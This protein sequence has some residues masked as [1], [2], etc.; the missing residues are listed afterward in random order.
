MKP[1][2]FVIIGQSNTGKSYLMDSLIDKFNLR[3]IGYRMHSIQFENE[4]KGYYISSI[5]DVKGYHNNIPVQTVLKSKHRINLTEVFDTFGVLCLTDVLNKPK[6]EY[7]CIILD[8]LGRGEDASP[9]FVKKI[10]E[11]LDSDATVF[12]LMKNVPSDLNS[13][14]RKRRDVLLYDMDNMSQDEIELNIADKL[15]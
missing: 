14:I 12:I 6:D 9:E 11:I 8:E 3:A 13:Q 5:M 10:N 2:K 4:F 1:N 15:R 7:D